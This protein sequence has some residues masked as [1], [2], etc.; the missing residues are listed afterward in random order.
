[1]D[2][3]EILLAAMRAYLLND[4]SGCCDYLGYYRDWVA[5]GGFEPLNGTSRYL[6]LKGLERL[7]RE[8]LT[9]ERA[10]LTRLLNMTPAMSD[11][12]SLIARLGE[13]NVALAR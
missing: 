4:L 11:M 9:E 2:P 8:Y 6:D 12:S 1:M 5:K 3:E 10:G 7:R 13:L